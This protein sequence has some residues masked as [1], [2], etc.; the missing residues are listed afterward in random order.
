MKTQRFRAMAI[1]G[2]SIDKD[3][4]ATGPL[5]LAEVTFQFPAAELR[6]I[7]SFLLARANEIESGTFTDGGRHLCDHDRHWVP[8]QWGDVIVVPPSSDAVED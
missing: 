4:D 6:R 3:R 1:Y 2:Y 5:Q 7:A 8:A